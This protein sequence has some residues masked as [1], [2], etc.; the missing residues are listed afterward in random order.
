MRI[1]FVLGGVLAALECVHAVVPE[2]FLPWDEAVPQLMVAQVAFALVYFAIMGFGLLR[3]RHWPR[4]LSPN[5]TSWL[6]G[7][8]LTYSVVQMAWVWGRPSEMVG[9]ASYSRMLPLFVS[10]VPFAVATFAAFFREEQEGAGAVGMIVACLAWLWGPL[11]IDTAYV[12]HWEGW[13]ADR[14]P[15]RIPVFGSLY[16]AADVLA[17]LYLFFLALLLLPLVA[18]GSVWAVWRGRGKRERLRR[19]AIGASLLALSLQ[20]VNWASFLSD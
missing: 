9:S 20:A 5:A 13:Y 15:A 3:L 4:R 17:L 12:A 18:L 19:A 10:G 16:Q 1:L 2:W 7:A 11:L 8:L 14:S 6:C